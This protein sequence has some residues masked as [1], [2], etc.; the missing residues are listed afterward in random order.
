LLPLCWTVCGFVLLSRA[1]THAQAVVELGSPPTAPKDV[2]GLPRRREKFLTTGGFTVNTTNRE[3]VRSFFNAI[4]PASD[5]VPINS[6]ADIS[7]CSAGTNS[8]DFGDSVIRRINWFRAMAGIPAVVTADPGNNAADQAAALMMSA[9]NLLDHNPTAS[10]SCFT[11]SG[12]NAAHNSNIALG[13]NG[14]A[15]VASYIQDRGTNNP[16]AGHRRWL[17]FPQTQIMGT[18]DM[19]TQGGFQAANAVWVF[20]NNFTNSRPAT[21]TKFIA[22]PPA[23]YVPKQVVCPRWSFAY[24]NANFTNATVSMTSNGV[25]VSVFKETVIDGYGEPTLVWVPMGLDST[26]S[27]PV[28]PFSGTDTVYTVTIGNVGFPIGMSNFTYSVTV[29]DPAV[30]GSDYYPPVIVGPA[31]A[32][33]G[34]SN[35]YSFN[36][37]SNASGYQW[38]YSRRSSFNL[39]DGAEAGLGNWTTNSSAFYSLITANPV[40]AGSFA[41]QMAHTNTSVQ[42]PNPTPQIMTLTN[43][44]SPLPGTTL[45]FRSLLAYAT[46]MEVAR[47]QASTNNGAAWFDLYT[48]AGN[49]TPET[50]FSTKTISLG[51]YAGLPLLLRFNYD[52]PTSG[53]ITY[54]PNVGPMFGWHFDNITITNSE[55]L[56]ATTTNSIAGASFQ[57][58][59]PQAGNF[60][61]QAQGVIFNDFP[62]DWG[63]IKQVVATTNTG[64]I[65]Q[66]DKLTISSSQARVDFSLQSGTA[67][68]YKLLSA[69]LPLGPWSTDSLAVLATNSPGSYRFTTTPNGAAR[70]YKVQT[71]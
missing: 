15:A 28:W 43:A 36:S 68:T 48:Q 69:A 9:N 19:P 31:F 35:A 70:F 44:L 41:F 42:N 45:Q 59:P 51:A 17:L 25:P 67:S 2:S 64:P 65:I 10:W 60:N 11:L 1:S 57:F 56:L 29:F 61:L 37:V 62:L 53:S 5:N 6:T 66:I 46:S 49:G 27:F 32:V 63:P 40:A 54:Y 50:G 12:S 55:Q 30:P 7:S 20:D 71:P 18:G 4:Y 14:A 8:A 58:N 38:R 16:A 34:Q 23:G 47:V 22:W 52:V 3:E 26:A 33:V 13:T 39:F 24:T 21:R